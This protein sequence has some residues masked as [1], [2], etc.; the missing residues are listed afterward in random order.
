M[1]SASLPGASPETM[2]SSV[3]T[4]LERSLGR[5]AGVNEMTSSS[6]LGSTRIILEFNFDRD[7][8][9]VIENFKQCLV[10]KYA[11]FD[12]RASRSEYWHFLLVYQ[13][14]FVA[15]LF[16]CAFLSY[17]SPLS[18]VVG[19]GFGLVILVLLSVI[20][21]IPGVAVSVRRLHDQGRSGGLVFIGFI[22]VIGTIILLIL[23]AL[24]GE[25]QPNRFG[26]PNGQV[27][28]TKQMARE[29]GLIDT[30]PSMGLTAGLFCAIFVL[31]FLVDK[32]LMTSAM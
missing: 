19:V 2:A 17:I 15:I 25:S 11:D 3:A 20:M 8:N 29:L 21:V 13:L 5:I 6:S 31:W 16:T 1:V 28:V 14:L 4:P 18:S 26:P 22:P 7:I 10:Y 27:V 30:T 24:P 12:G 9:G 32:L 23:M